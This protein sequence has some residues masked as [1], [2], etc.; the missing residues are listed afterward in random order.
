[1]TTL[2]HFI[3]SSVTI[4]GASWRRSSHSTAANNCV[5]TARPGPGLTAVR[6]SKDRCGPALLFGAQAWTEFVRDLVDGGLAPVGARRG[7]PVREVRSR[8]GH[9]HEAHARGAVRAMTATASSI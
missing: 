6:D 9:A 7:P 1:M 8:A 2:P 4:S 5:E 3:S